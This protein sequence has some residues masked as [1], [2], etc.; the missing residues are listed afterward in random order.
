[1]M[2]TGLAAITTINAQAVLNPAGESS[3]IM[4]YTT[5]SLGGITNETPAD[6]KG[7]IF[8]FS[9]SPPVHQPATYSPGTGGRYNRSDPL[10]YMITATIHEVSHSHMIK[11]DQRDVISQEYLNHRLI[12]S[13]VRVPDRT[14]LNE[15]QGYGDFTRE[16]IINI[17]NSPPLA[18]NLILGNPAQF[19][20]RIQDEY[21]RL[22]DSDAQLINRGTTGLAPNTPIVRPGPT[23][24]RTI[25]PVLNTTPCYPANSD[26]CDDDYGTIEE[27]GT[28]ID[29]IIAGP[30]GIAETSSLQQT[31]NSR[32]I[33]NSSWRN[34]E[35]NERIGSTEINSRHQ[36]GDAVDLAVGRNMSI[37][38]RIELHCILETA[39]KSIA[40]KAFAE[41]LSLPVQCD[42]IS[43]ETAVTHIHAQR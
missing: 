42:A 12:N 21:N 32:L 4:W 36:Y 34:P 19:A 6:R 27:D 22:I 5:A 43:A 38:R 31:N 9:L 8:S 17:P 20:Q 7:P 18:Y 1:M 26:T 30:N 28:V 41:H 13:I 37:E 40:T 15:I 16:Q 2:G 3:Q 33:L 29:V 14:E 23:V 24:I 35:R 11:Q 39:A 10:S 25:G